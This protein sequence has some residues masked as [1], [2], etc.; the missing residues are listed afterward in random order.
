[1]L[2]SHPNYTARHARIFELL[3]QRELALTTTRRLDDPARLH[4]SVDVEKQIRKDALDSFVIAK[5]KSVKLRGVV[6]GPLLSAFG[7]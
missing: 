5:A 3:R 4:G 6:M 2:P 7:R 1:M